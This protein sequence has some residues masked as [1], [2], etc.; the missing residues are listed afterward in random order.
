[1]TGFIK[2]IIFF[3]LFLLVIRFFRLISRYWSSSKKNIDD[4]R[5]NQKKEPDQFENVE[6]AKFREIDPDKKEKRE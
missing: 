6:D 5:Q 3:I 2:V 1:M 4:L